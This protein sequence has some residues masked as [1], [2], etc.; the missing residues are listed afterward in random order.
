MQGN[1]AIVFAKSKCCASLKRLRRT[2][3]IWSSLKKGHRLGLRLR[4]ALRFVLDIQLENKADRVCDRVFASLM[5]L[6]HYRPRPGHS[7]RQSRSHRQRDAEHRSIQQSI[8]IE[9]PKLSGSI[10]AKKKPVGM[11]PFRRSWSSRYSWDLNSEELLDDPALWFQP[12][13]YSGRDQLRPSI[14]GKYI[15]ILLPTT[16]AGQSVRADRGGSVKAC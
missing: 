14:S 8:M 6:E 11:W 16:T 12:F 9:I 13:T 2:S 7:P 1:L 15:A 3:K 5:V 10:N 4:F